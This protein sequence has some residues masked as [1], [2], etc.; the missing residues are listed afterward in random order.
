MIAYVE[1]TAATKRHA[2]VSTLMQEMAMRVTK[3]DAEHGL[4]P[5]CTVYVGLL[6]LLLTHGRSFEPNQLPSAYFFFNR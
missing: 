6:Y 4:E 1:H 2:C 3:Q 5:V